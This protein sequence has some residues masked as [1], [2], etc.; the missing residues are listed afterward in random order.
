MLLLVRYCGVLTLLETMALVSSAD[1][2]AVSQSLSSEGITVL[3]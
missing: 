3:V 2:A 1:S